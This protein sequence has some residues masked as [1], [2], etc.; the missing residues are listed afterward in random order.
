MIKRLE[1]AKQKYDFVNESL[2]KLELEIKKF[3]ILINNA[4]TS[5]SSN[6]AVK[7][8]NDL[9]KSQNMYQKQI[10]DLEDKLKL[11]RSTEE[12]KRSVIG[13]E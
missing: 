6:P 4:N 7:T 1:I 12:E 10:D 9:T 5:V 8:W 3:G 13:D 11:S 2:A